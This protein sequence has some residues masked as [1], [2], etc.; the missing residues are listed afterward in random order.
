MSNKY[1]KEKFGDN[2]LTAEHQYEFDKFSQVIGYTH[3]RAKTLIIWMELGLKDWA[4]RYL[5][6]RTL[7]SATLEFHKIYYGD[8]LGEQ[9]YKELNHK[10]TA[11]FD[12]SHE[13]QKRKG[14]LASLVLSGSSEHSIRTIGFWIRKGYTE[15][16]SK[17]KVKEIQSTNTLARYIKKYGETEGRERFNTRKAAWTDRMSSPSIG[18]SRS[19]GLQ[20]YIERYGE[21]EGEKQYLAMRK[22]RNAAAS[23]GRAS[24]ESC[25]A[26]RYVLEYLDQ[27]KIGYYF[28]VEGNKE[29]FIYDKKSKKSFF[30]DLVVPSLSIIFEYHGSGCHPNPVW[31]QIK[32]GSWRHVFT[33]ISADE[34]FQK[35]QY[36][37]ILA[38]SVGWTVFEIYSSADI[39][40]ESKLYSRF[41]DLA[42]SYKSIG[43]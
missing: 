4:D 34:Q 38:E 12:H 3:D 15:E 16:Q 17:N 27:K 8:E 9:K 26:L 14:E 37:K 1:Y 33:K 31:D 10:K 2:P 11:K 42:N 41:C 29:W 32:W 13:S 22:K 7:H 21:I 6:V 24:K 40:V 43:I 35:D 18:K 25:K 39:N 36:K 30:Y 23:I 28:G 5:S 19:L 20:R